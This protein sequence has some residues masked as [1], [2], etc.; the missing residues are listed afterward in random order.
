MSEE[1]KSPSGA[2]LSPTPMLLLQSHIYSVPVEMNAVK[3]V[4]F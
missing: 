3:G 2:T 1:I 4:I